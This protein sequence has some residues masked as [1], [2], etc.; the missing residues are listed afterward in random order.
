MDKKKVVA[1]KATQRASASGVLAGL[2]D[3]RGDYGPLSAEENVRVTFPQLQA[4][5]VEAQWGG[6]AK[7]ASADGVQFGA[8]R[9]TLRANFTGADVRLV[10]RSASGPAINVNKVLSRCCKLREPFVDRAVGAAT[11]AP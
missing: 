9:P 4:Q 10:A 8:G 7:G 1:K 2:E 11:Q 6:L 5:P 3:G